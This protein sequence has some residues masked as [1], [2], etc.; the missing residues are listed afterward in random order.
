MDMNIGKEELLKFYIFYTG[1]R[2]VVPF[3]KNKKKYIYIMKRKPSAQ[4][5]NRI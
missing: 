1:H 5:S 3:N 4:N 2:A